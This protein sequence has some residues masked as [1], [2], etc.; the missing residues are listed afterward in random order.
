[1]VMVDLKNS[2]ARMNNYAAVLHDRVC[3]VVITRVA[4]Y[5]VWDWN[6]LRK[7]IHMNKMKYFNIS[8]RFVTND[9]F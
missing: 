1:M 9:S 5:M 6:V 3:S 8:D 7:T 2:F 4:S